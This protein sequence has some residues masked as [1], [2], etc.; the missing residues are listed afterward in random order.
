MKLKLSSESIS[1]PTDHHLLDEDTPWAI[2]EAYKTLRTNV[3]LALPDEGHRIIAFTSAE[4]HDGKTTNAINF[5]ISLG[6]IEKK[7]LLIDGDL[8]KPMIARRLEIESSPGLSDIIAGQSRARNVLVH[9]EKHNIDV[10]AAGTLTPDPT[11]LL[12]SDRMKM[13]ILELKKVYEYIV[14]DLP[15]ATVVSDASILSD[16]IDGFL[17]VVRHDV[18]DYRS[19]SDM[20]DQ[21]KMANAQIIGFIY[22][23]STSGEKQYNNNYGYKK[24]GYYYQQ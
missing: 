7:V 9:D 13:I 1:S 6:Q 24:Y 17:L 3:M 5:A 20:I 15:P 21:L 11:L 18:T 12:Q 4:P 22:N 2:R 10:I 16:L 23:D 19:I 14:I 8:R